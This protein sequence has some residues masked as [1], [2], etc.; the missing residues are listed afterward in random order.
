MTQTEKPNERT[1]RVRRVWAAGLALAAAIVVLGLIAPLIDATGFSGPIQ[2]AVED[3]LGRKIQFSKVHLT[4]FSG[5]G[6]SLE[7]V[8]IA[9]DPRYGLEPFAWVPTLHARLRIDKL[10]RGE[11]RLSSLRLEDPSLNLV[12]RSDGTWNVVELVQRLSAPRRMPL[13]LFPA[14]EV[15]DGRIDF[16]FGTR[17]S[18]F[19]VLEA[20]LSIYPERSGKLYLQ[21]SGSPA[22][23]DRAGNGFGHL[24]GTANWYL[25]PPSAQAN[26]LES[27]ITLDPSNL[28]EL[29]TLFE[30]EDIGVHGSIS[31][32]AR[33][34]GPLDALRVSGDLQVGD[35][36]RWDLLPSSG[37]DWRIKYSGDIDWAAHR[38]NVHTV[39]AREGET[40]PISVELR[41]EDFLTHPEWT[42]SARLDHTPVENLLPLGRRMGLS[43]PQ[44]LKVTG[45]VQGTLGY[46]NR[47][48]LGGAISISD[49]TAT[50][51]NVPPLH[52]QMVSATI[53]P[54][55]IHFDPAVIDTPEGNL[56]AGGDYYLSAPQSVAALKA[57]G[58][59]VDALKSTINAWFGTPTELALLSGGRINGT[60]NYAHQQSGPPNWSGQF[61]F[62]DST[63]QPE[64]IAIPLEQA[65]GQVTFD[66]ANLELTRFAAKLGEQDIRGSYRY[67]M[68]SKRP[69]RLRIEMA[70]GDLSDLE[71]AL[72]PALTAQD[73]LARWHVTKRKIPV[74][75]AG[76]NLEGDIA[77]NA[78]SIN[79]TA[80]GPMTSHFI[81]RGANL[82]L[83]PIQINLPEGLIRGRGSVNLAS[84]A[85]R[86]RFNARV[87]GFP[88]RGG[89]LS[90]DG[91]FE[92]TGM[93]TDS[94]ENLHAT[95]SFAGADLNFSADDEF[96][97]I[98]GQFD[99]SFMEG[100]PDLKISRIQASDGL[101]AWNGT[102]ASQS[103]G[104]LILDLEHAG[105]QRRVISTLLPETVSTVSS[106][107]PART[108]G[109]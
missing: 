81:W 55:R 90:A 101:D 26:R 21:F 99:F 77:V 32:N 54:D 46:S 15:A 62:T 103:D 2:R 92:T 27:D 79:G 59:S 75:L 58:F 42:L 17:K 73:L 95:G 106:L 50:M 78:F 96:R 85:P 10:L 67:L 41:A 13:N 68:N 107:A 57:T 53:F 70:A 61:Q 3:A 80:L 47:G 7:D 22:R 83:A 24:R 52:T 51:P 60:F 18:T 72:A 37:E 105:R 91:E 9:E 74:W 66:A 28:S 87:S 69:E 64:G 25:K 48:G 86:Y 38:L 82:Q 36:H 100:W 33:V 49:A 44:D 40:N 93:G 16:K 19:Y 65:Q 34:A 35:V 108:D 97:K 12:K 11:F 102:G 84:Y 89:V 94:L 109:R 23:T 104:K 20:D 63:L 39:S 29:T 31:G 43:L 30:G 71:K 1:S 76:R 5:P 88:W 6:F 14:F 98:S 8:S 56:S 45:A 4:L